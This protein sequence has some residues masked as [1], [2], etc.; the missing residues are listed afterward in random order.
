[1]FTKVFFEPWVGKDYGSTKSIFQKKVLVLGDS[2]YCEK[3]ETCGNR[4]LHSGCTQFT[5]NTI[6]V[7]LNPN[8]HGKWKKTYST[9]LN[10]IFGKGT[11]LSE[12]TRFFDSVAFYNFLQVSAGDN[13]T[14]ANAYNYYDPKHL[15]AFYEMLNEVL[16]DIILLWGNRVWDVLPNDWGDGEAKKGDPIP[17]RNLAFTQYLTYPFHGTEITLVGTHHPCSGFPSEFY[18]EVFSRLGV[19]PIMKPD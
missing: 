3:C 7:Y 1:M 15:A 13:A 9:F 17:V 14:S 18:H 12:R 5:Q 16:P 2:H 10:S 8:E 6:G 19:V 4:D 11:S